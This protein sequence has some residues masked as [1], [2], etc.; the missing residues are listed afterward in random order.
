MDF[1]RPLQIVTPTLD[2]DVLAV[3]AGAREEFTGRGIQRVLGRG[4]EPG[5]RKAADRLVDQGVVLR[6]SAGRANLYS[7]NRDH[8]AAPYVEGLAALRTELVGRLRKAIAEWEEPAR[9][10]LLFG[11]V[12]RGE[13]DPKSD[14]DLLVVRDQGVNEDAT[15]WRDQVATLENDAAAWT[16][17]EARVL[18]YGEEDLADGSVAAVV[19]EALRDGVELDGSRRELRAALREIGK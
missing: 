16:G 10:V 12:A 9:W 14:L 6:R 4:S 17:N 13:A 11:S 1:R 18:E 5:V 2:G 19:E 15:V 7:L 8:L 3:L